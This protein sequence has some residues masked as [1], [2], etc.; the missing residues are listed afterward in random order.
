MRGGQDWAAACVRGV[1]VEG[2]GVGCGRASVWREGRRA[3]EGEAGRRVGGDGG[4]GRRVR[5][6][7]PTATHAAPQTRCV[8]PSAHTEPH[9]THT[10]THTRAHTHTHARTH[11]RTHTHTH[12]HLE[13]NAL[14]LQHAR[15]HLGLLHAGGAHLAQHD[16]STHSVSTP[17][18]RQAQHEHGKHSMTTA[19]AAGRALEE[20]ARRGTGAAWAAQRSTAQHSTAGAAWTKHGARSGTAPARAAVRARPGSFMNACSEQLP[21]SFPPTRAAPSCA[22]AGSPAPPPSTCRSQTCGSEEGVPAG[23][24]GDGQGRGGLEG[25]AQGAARRLPGMQR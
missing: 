25:W 13:G 1:G 16:H 23:A 19:C 14:L 3:G 20:G 4:G 2:R 11:A 18:A 8:N 5:K 10:H 21:R 17:R 24:G 9:S 7:A 6:H 15:Q 12:T 22:C